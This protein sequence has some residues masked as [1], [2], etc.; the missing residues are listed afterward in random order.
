MA[1]TSG[2]VSAYQILD[3][4]AERVAAHNLSSTSAYQI[5][6]EIVSVP[7]MEK[8]QAMELVKVKVLPPYDQLAFML[9]VK[10]VPVRVYEGSLFEVRRADLKFLEEAGIPYEL[11]H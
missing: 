11:L 8:L 1:G 9:L 7:D 4:S 5:P 2:V 6:V 10:K 3:Y